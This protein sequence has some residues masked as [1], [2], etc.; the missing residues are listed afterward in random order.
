M[1]LFLDCPISD[2]VVSKVLVDLTELEIA[3][4]TCTLC[5][6][7]ACLAPQ[8]HESLHKAGGHFIQDVR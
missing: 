8:R 4:I 5:L 2:Y 6:Y 1:D 3:E 7:N